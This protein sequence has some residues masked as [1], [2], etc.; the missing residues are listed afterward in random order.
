MENQF[1]KGNVVKH[2]ASNENMV[3][4]DTNLDYRDDVTCRY[5]N[6][7]DGQYCQKTFKKFEFD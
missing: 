6:R 3:V 2:K 7:K 1:K 5:F 4:L